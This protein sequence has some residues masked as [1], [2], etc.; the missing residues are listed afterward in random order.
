MLLYVEVCIMFV[1][2]VYNSNFS[3]MLCVLLAGEDK[4]NKFQFFEDFMLCRF[5]LL[6]TWAKENELL[7]G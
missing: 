1:V 5:N 2:V 7:D 6:Q 4:N 3:S